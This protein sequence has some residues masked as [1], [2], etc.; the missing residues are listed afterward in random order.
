MIKVMNQLKPV[1]K[2]MANGGLGVL[3]ED[4]HDQDH[5]NKVGPI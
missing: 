5:N 3:K 2:I 4:E 1:I